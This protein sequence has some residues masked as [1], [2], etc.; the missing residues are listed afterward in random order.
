MLKKIEMKDILNIIL[1]RK[2]STLAFVIICMMI[3]GCYEYAKYLNQDEEYIMEGSIYIKNIKNNEEVPIEDF[4]NS[5]YNLTH[6]SEETK[7]N[8]AYIQKKIAADFKYEQS[9][10]DIY[11]FSENKDECKLLY[12]TLIGSSVDAIKYFR[13]DLSMD[14]IKVMD[15]PELGIRE[16]KGED[17]VELN[18]NPYSSLIAYILSGGI[19]AFLILFILYYIKLTRDDILY[20]KNDIFRLMEDMEFKEFIEL[21]DYKEDIKYLYE[22]FL[23]EKVLSIVNCN[24]IDNNLRT[25]MLRDFSQLCEETNKNIIFINC[26]NTREDNKK[27]NIEENIKKINNFIDVLDVSYIDKVNMVNNFEKINEIIN[28]YSIVIIN[29]PRYDYIMRFGLGKYE[30]KK[31]VIILKLGE[32]TISDLKNSLNYINNKEFLLLLK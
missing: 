24:Y 1:K 4:V 31:H 22:I 3:F 20:N 11:V 10:L 8:K 7:L 14:L 19:F 25:E 29:V 17:F 9:V 23:S 26:F 28:K 27:V 15:E 16:L 13:E 2:L 18:G 6:V 32:S 12:N 30:V 5:D 21:R